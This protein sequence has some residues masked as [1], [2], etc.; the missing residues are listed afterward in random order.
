M[1]D[2]LLQQYLAPVAH[3]VAGLLTPAEWSAMI[4]LVSGTLIFTH[5]A[6]IV[7]R[8]SPIP[9][10]G[11]NNAIHLVAGLIGLLIA[12]PVWPD[13]GRVPFWMAGPVAS[14]GAIGI[15]KGFFPVL[16]YFFPR[17]ADNLNA[18]RR[19]YDLGPPPATPERRSARP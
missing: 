1:L 17:L 13:S 3:W 16:S 15:F 5:F 19:R 6:K 7:W 2:T 8:L 14:G 18:N 12:I 11:N 9:G 4:W 10:G